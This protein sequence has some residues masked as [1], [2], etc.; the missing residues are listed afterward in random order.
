[1]SIGSS[2]LG[3]GGIIEKL[4]SDDPDDANITSIFDKNGSPTV[5]DIK[6]LINSFLLEF[7]VDSIVTAIIHVTLR[8][9]VEFIIE[10]VKTFTEF[11]LQQLQVSLLNNNYYLIFFKTYS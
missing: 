9:I 2:S 11:G 7:R 5:P 1:M 3:A 4:W 10:E 8:K 6:A